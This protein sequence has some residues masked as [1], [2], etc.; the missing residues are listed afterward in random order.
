MDI[1]VWNDKGGCGKSTLSVNLA[2]ALGA[3]LI[4]ADPQGDSSRY[5]AGRGLPC[6]S[7]PTKAEVLAAVGGPGHRV[8]DCAP[9][10]GEA[11]LTAVAS[12]DLVILPTRTGEADLVAL[13]R[14]LAVVAVVR[15]KN[16][17]IRVA[18]ALVNTRD[19]GRARGVE[20]VLRSQAAASGYHWLGRLSTRVG[21]EEAYAQQRPL[22]EVGGAVAY[23]FRQ[24]LSAVEAILDTAGTRDIPNT[25]VH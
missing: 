14:A 24:I 15:T 25:A 10:Q 16:P 1:A 5:A 9:G 18:V 11:S 6:I 17:R 12:A 23:E 4:D 22:L 7:A 13:S 19:T 21:V 2:E 20:D 3:A 8:V